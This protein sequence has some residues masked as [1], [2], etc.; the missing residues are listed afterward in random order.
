M[1][2]E[3]EI[4]KFRGFKNKK[5]EISNKITV[6]AGKNGTSKSTILGLLAQPFVFYGN[7]HFKGMK[8][9]EKME[10]LKDKKEYKNIFGKSFETKYSE[11]FKFSPIYDKENEH[12]YMLHLDSKKNVKNICYM[13]TKS[14][15]KDVIRF[16]HYESNTFGSY[17]VYKDFVYPTTYLGLS[18]LFPIGESK[19]IELNKILLE[20]DEIFKEFVEKYNMIL[21]QTENVS[22]NLLKKETGETLGINTEYYDAYSNSAGQDNVS[23]ILGSLLSFK[24]L[25]K[26]MG[27]EY[28]GGLLL[29]DELDTTLF[30]ASMTKLFDCL[31]D[32]SNK[33]NLQIVF[34]THSLELIKHILH[35]NKTDIKLYYFKKYNQE[36]KIIKNPNFSEIY[37]DIQFTLLEDN[38]KEKIR[39]FT[40]DSMARRFI[41]DILKTKLKISLL[42]FKE[43]DLSWTTMKMLNK[44]VDELKNYLFIY[45]GDVE[46]SD[47]IKGKK[48]VLKLPLSRPLEVEIMNF[49]NDEKSAESEIWQLFGFTQEYFLDYVHNIIKVDFSSTESCKKALKNQNFFEKAYTQFIKFWPKKNNK[50][51]TDFENSFKKCY[52]EVKKIESYEYEELQK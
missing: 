10:I 27:E 41:K 19:K 26:Q 36:I 20:D 7:K 15:I 50:A 39:I 24:L 30:A 45:D 29:I 33:L 13:N 35:K 4:I 37:S 8:L 11:I 3:L 23:K 22:L 28:K 12:P 46:D 44:T 6:I 47:I 49:F 21:R 38:K 1:I 31:Y 34:T 17:G 51:I 52:N 16:N 2:K 42:E 25:K 48:N 14:R 9:E 32:Y 40:E 18:R 5:I 43:V